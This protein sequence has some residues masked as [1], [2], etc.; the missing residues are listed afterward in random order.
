MLKQLKYTDWSAKERLA[1]I[2]KQNV[3]RHVAYGAKQKLRA[4]VLRHTKNQN[5]QMEH[6][7]LKAATVHGNLHAAA[8][9]RMKY[10]AQK[11]LR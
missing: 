2:R 6:D 9:A 7:R 5:E 10:L 4:N 1:L 3:E 8:E 11:L